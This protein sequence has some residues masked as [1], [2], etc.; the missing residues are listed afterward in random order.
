MIDPLPV[1]PTVPTPGRGTMGQGG[2]ERDTQRDSSGTSSL[3][4]LAA[5]VLARDKRGTRAVIPVPHTFPLVPP[6]QAT[7]PHPPQASP[8]VP[9]AWCEGV[10]GLAA[11]SPLG[12]PGGLPWRRPRPVCCRRTGRNCTGPDGTPSTYSGCTPQRRPPTRP[13]GDWRGCWAR[14]GR[15]WT[16]CPT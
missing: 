8:G 16:W 12:T 13:A 5:G 3:K 4:R 6:V 1:C 11:P 15:F 7:A 10:A 2:N 14:P 9:A